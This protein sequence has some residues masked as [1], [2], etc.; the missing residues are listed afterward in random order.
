MAAIRVHKVVGR[1]D[2]AL[3]RKQAYDHITSNLGKVSYVIK[4]FVDQDQSEDP[5]FVDSLSFMEQHVLTTDPL[6]QML[7]L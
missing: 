2:Y 6:E 3:Q 1:P 7:S 4:N 5:D